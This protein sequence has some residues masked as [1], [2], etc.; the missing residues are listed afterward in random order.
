MSIR[1][2][3]VNIDVVSNGYVAALSESGLGDSAPREAVFKTA[4]ELSQWLDSNLPKP[5]GG[6]SFGVCIVLPPPIPPGGLS[7]FMD[8]RHT[9]VGEPTVGP[10][11]AAAAAMAEY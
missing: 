3:T 6:F 7:G 9:Y 2:F 1:C 10:A 11:L 8:N 5:D 4:Y